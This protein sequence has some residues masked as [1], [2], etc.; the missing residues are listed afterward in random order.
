MFWNKLSKI[1]KTENYNP[2]THFLL[3]VFW[4][5]NSESPDQH[6]EEVLKAL[7]LLGITVSVHGG[8]NYIATDLHSCLTEPS[9]YHISNVQQQNSGCI[10]ASRR[11][12]KQSCFSRCPKLYTAGCCWTPAYHCQTGQHS[13]WK[14]SAVIWIVICIWKLLRFLTIH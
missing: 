14:K 7:S 8:A 2:A 11:T 10:A 13:G 3:N 12:G 6:Y 5:K 9:V 1:S 4:Q